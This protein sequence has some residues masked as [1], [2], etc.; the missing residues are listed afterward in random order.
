M[1]LAEL[2]NKLWFD[3][4]SP[5]NLLVARAIIALHALWILM[6]R[7]RL[8]ELLQ[9]P[10]AFWK[11]VPEITLVRFGIGAIPL[12][13]EWIL[14]LSAH[15]FLLFAAFNLVPRFSCLASSLL[16][17]HFGPYEQFIVWTSFTS[18]GGLTLSVLALAIIS[19]AK[20]PRWNDEPSWEYRWPIVSIQMLLAFQY[21][22]PGLVK[23]HV[24]GLRWFG[25]DNI[26]RET[27]RIAALWEPQWAGLIIAN[28]WVATGVGMFALAMELLFPLAVISK[29]A[30]W[31][32]IPLAF[33][34]HLMRAKMWGLY[35]LSF[36]LLLLFLDW[37]AILDRVRAWSQSR[38]AQRWDELD[39]E[40]VP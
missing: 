11:S 23:L 9:W 13:V 20:T 4:E 38:P 24:S 32:L 7:P 30:R 8:P 15:L 35:F 22:L 27:A 12:T 37:N 31:I 33:A 26:S 39:H 21:L 19:F 18:L 17:Y 10:G 36:P 25:A 14:F 29:R 34:A 6:S 1:M 16:L 5:R 3:P 2:W 28:R 40:S